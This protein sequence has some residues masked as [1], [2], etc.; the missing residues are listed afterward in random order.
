[1]R[2]NTWAHQRQ[3]TDLPPIRLEIRHLES[4]RRAKLAGFQAGTGAAEM[5]VI[6]TLHLHIDR[7]DAPTTMHFTS[8]PVRIGRGEEA[9]CRLEFPYVSRLHARIDLVDGQLVLQDVGSRT[10]TWILDHA[11]RR[12]AWTARRSWRFRS[13]RPR[14]YRTHPR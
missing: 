2:E 12:R 10:G 1:M 13:S 6:M 8:F 14:T 3:V 7:G 4:R 9:E 5:R 11:R